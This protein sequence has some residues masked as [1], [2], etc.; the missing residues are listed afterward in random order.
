[1]NWAWRLTSKMFWDS[2]TALQVKAVFVEH[3]REHLRD[4][5]LLRR[6]C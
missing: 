3:A 4:L 1:M 2:A 6:N 5:A